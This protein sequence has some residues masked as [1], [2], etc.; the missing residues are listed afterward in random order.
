MRQLFRKAVLVFGA[1]ELLLGLLYCVLVLSSTSDPLGNSIARGVAGLTVGA[2]L[3]VLVP[4][5]ILAWRDRMLPLAGALVAVSP[6]AWFVLM[7]NA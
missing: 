6:L 1:I 5:L 2:V 7:V 4:G 3:V